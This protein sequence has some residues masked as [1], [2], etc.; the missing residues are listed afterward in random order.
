MRAKVMR[1]QLASYVLTSDSSGQITRS[2]AWG[3]SLRQMSY[4]DVEHTSSIARTFEGVVPEVYVDFEE[5]IAEDGVDPDLV[6]AS[7][8]HVGVS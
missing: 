8:P 7:E 4:Q 3:G 2:I 6:E 5:A 1:A